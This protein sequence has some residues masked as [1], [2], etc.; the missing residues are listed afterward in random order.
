MDL[1]SGNVTI[2]AKSIAAVPFPLPWSI[3]ADGRTALLVNAQTVADTN[4]AT[5]GLGEGG[6]FVS[7]LHDERRVENEPAISPN[8]AWV[9]YQESAQIAG[10]YEINIR[11]FPGVMLTRIPVSPGR[12]PVFSRDGSELFFF[13]GTGIS[14]ATV[15]YQPGLRIGPIRQLFK[16]AYLWTA[17]GRAWDVDPNGRRFLMIRRPDSAAPQGSAAPRPEIQVVVNWAEEVK[18]RVPVP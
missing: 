15:T 16:G 9:A 17:P 8:G 18:S 14:G 12:S 3:T 2:V 5:L 7:V 4:I 1:E 11:P 13:D 10:P 6:T